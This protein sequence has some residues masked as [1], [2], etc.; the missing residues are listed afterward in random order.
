LHA[1]I[2]TFAQSEKDLAHQSFARSKVI[3]KHAG[4]RVQGLGKGSQGQV[5]ESVR[6]HIIDGL[7]AK[8]GADVGF[9]RSS[10]YDVSSS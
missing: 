3:D 10:H 9:G 7:V 8:P 2:L 6:E 5:A 1:R 4:V